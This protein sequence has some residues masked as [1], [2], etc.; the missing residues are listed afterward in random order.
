MLSASKEERGLNQLYEWVKC[1]GGTV[2][3]REV[4]QAHRKYKTAQD[5]KLALNELV[6]SGWADWVPTGSGSPGRPT[7][8][9][10]LREGMNSQSNTWNTVDVDSVDTLKRNLS[11]TDQVVDW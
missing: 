9:L 7:R 10:V 8:K 2:T 6:N 1:K 4:Q 5:A 11:D 3:A